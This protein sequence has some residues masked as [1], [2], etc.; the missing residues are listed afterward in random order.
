[1]FLKVC[2]A[3]RT[4]VGP[5]CVPDGDDVWLLPSAAT[6]AQNAKINPLFL[7]NADVSQ[8]INENVPDR[9]CSRVL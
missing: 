2:A 6:P 9:K 1:M 7:I 5:D 8:T 3:V 4:F